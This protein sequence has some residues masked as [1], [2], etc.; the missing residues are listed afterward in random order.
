T[1]GAVLS[2]WIRRVDKYMECL[3]KLKADGFKVL[4]ADIRGESHVDFSEQKLV[5]ALGNE[6]NGL[7]GELLEKS[8]IKFRIPF[9][10]Q[11]IESLNVSV[12]GAV[13]MFCVSQGVG[14]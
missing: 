3:D 13:V 6:G 12:S 5:V 7:T 14:W 1:A 4:A 9:E 10:S 11:K 8:D 2:L